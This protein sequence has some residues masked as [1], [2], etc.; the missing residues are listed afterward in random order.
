MF[1]RSYFIL[2]F[3]FGTV[4]FLFVIAFLLF[5]RMESIM[6]ED[7]KDNFIVESKHK[8]EALNNKIKNINERFTAYTSLPL[9]SSIRFYR[10][11]LNEAAIKH[12]IRQ[13]ELY[14]F[15]TIRNRDE[16]LKVRYINAKASEVFVVEKDQIQSNLNDRSLDRSIKRYINLRKG[17]IAQTIDYHQ[18]NIVSLSWWIPVFVSSRIHQGV[19]NFTIDFKE[20]KKS[21]LNIFTSNNAIVCISDKKGNTIISNATDDICQD[22][23]NNLFKISDKLV[24]NHL[25]WDVSVYN[26]TNKFTSQVKQLKSFVFFTVLP[27]IS[28]MAFIFIVIFSNKIIVSI[29]K[30]VAYIQAAGRQENIHLMDIDTQRKDEL[31]ILAV[32]MKRSSELLYQ[33]RKQLEATNYDLESYS[34]TLAHDLRS[35]LR[36]ITSF[37]QILEMDCQEKLDSEDREY[38][39]RIINASKRM[40]VLIDDIL[41]LSRQSS[42]D[43]NATENLN[44][45]LIATHVIDALKETNTENKELKISIQDNVLARADAE[46][47][48]IIFENLLGNAW[49]YSSKNDFIEISFTATTENGETIYTIKDSGVGFDMKY[50]NKLFKP[51]QRLHRVE[52]FE[53]TGIGLASV[54]RMIKRHN[55]KIWIESE[56]N[57]GTSVHFSLW[58]EKVL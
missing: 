15:N 14:F 10:L 45:S 19:M 57:V 49:K 17:D 48:K 46:L 53:G 43:I 8:I 30:L 20:F 11:T 55:G 37:S 5:N 24:I 44:L 42:S 58:S 26:D 27:V 35:P 4:F 36:A 16:L 56:E 29:N 2:V 18:G 28:L 12:D 6:I 54:K 51:F 31:G 39:E 9:F 22:N 34:Y 47:F 52:E 13:L 23:V 41:E 40:S 33:H 21:V 32:E 3:G 50:V 1:L 7:I 38:L 25:N